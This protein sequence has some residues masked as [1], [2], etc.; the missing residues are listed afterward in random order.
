M[1]SQFLLKHGFI[2][3]LF[4]DEYTCLY[5][6]RRDHSDHVEANEE[7]GDRCVLM[8]N[9]IC[10][11]S[12]EKQLSLGSSLSG[13]PLNVFPNHAGGIPADQCIRGDIFCDDGTG[14]NDRAITD[15]YSF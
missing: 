1:L 12:M 6:K 15:R 8:I 10:G 9:Q 3:M 11:I 14:R 13:S 5:K 7:C 4:I 2:W